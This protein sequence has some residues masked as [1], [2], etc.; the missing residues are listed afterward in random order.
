MRAGGRADHTCAQKALGLLSVRQWCF[1]RTQG[2]ALSS[3][4]FFRMETHKDC[5]AARKQ[6]VLARERGSVG[7]GQAVPRPALRVP[8][9]RLR[10]G[11]VVGDGHAVV[12]GQWERAGVAV[13]GEVAGGHH[14]PVGVVGG[15]GGHGGGECGIGGRPR[16]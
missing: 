7:E 10:P 4:L 12:V 14:P 1:F 8:G 2:T 16:W 11:G 3:L 9:E 5:V 13:Q 15:R 6:H